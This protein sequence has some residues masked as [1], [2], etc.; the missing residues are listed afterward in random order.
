MGVIPLGAQCPRIGD[1]S[2][3]WLTRLAL[4]NHQ[5]GGRRHCDCASGESQK[6]TTLSRHS[7]V[8]PQTKAPTRPRRK[9]SCAMV[10]W[11]ALE[12]ERIFVVDRIIGAAPTTPLR[13]LND[14][15]FFSEVAV[16]AAY[17][18]AAN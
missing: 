7:C 15:Y 12:M 3:S 2:A 17:T 18:E 8:P 16:V 4:C 1:H 9:A 6:L 11:T 13:D 14:L 5:A 10:L